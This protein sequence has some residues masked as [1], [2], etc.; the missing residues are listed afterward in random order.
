MGFSV[1]RCI[2]RRVRVCVALVAVS[3]PLAGADEPNLPQAEP[4]LP[5]EPPAAEA[6]PPG[7]PPPAPKE[8][9]GRLAGEL[10]SDFKWSVN[11][12]AQDGI[13]VVKSPSHAG[14]LLSTPAFY[15]VTLASAAALGTA[16]GLD[17]PARD[18]FRHI[19]DKDAGYLESWGTVALFGTTGVLYGY[20][21]LADEAR[22]R[23]YALTGLLSA[24]VSGALTSALKVTFG[25]DRPRD[26]QGHNAWFKGGSSFVSGETTPAFALAADI[27]EY[28]DNRW[29]VALPA[30][31]AAASVGLGR[32]GKDAHW[33]SD[34][35][36]SALL[37]VGTTELLLH[38]HAMHDVDPN[39]WR[40]FPVVMNH[41]V[42]VGMTVAW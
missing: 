33:L 35:T 39:R 21:L 23:Q 16:Y 40:V 17:Q 26:N 19:S 20:G 14:E 37:G 42:G 4:T 1:L 22:A 5:Q 30:Y 41:T 15:W 27:S 11:N 7:Q 8:F 36:G 29:Y 25:R 9:P 38:M 6:P 31:V 2:V 12:I 32:M 18:Q 3:A 10:E 34:I 13:D 24:G 28:A